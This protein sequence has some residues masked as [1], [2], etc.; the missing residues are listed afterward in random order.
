MSP[1]NSL[2]FKTK[3]P[4]LAWKLLSI[5]LIGVMLGS[6]IFSM[7][8]IY[9]NIYRTLDDVNTIVVLNSNTSLDKINQK[10][11]DRAQDL[12]QLKRNL[13]ALP[14]QYR[15]IFVKPTTSTPR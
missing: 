6:I 2:S 11:Y 15:N 13:A 12:V 10:S 5:G 4:F 14:K 9:V 1:I 7:Y 3:T 8:F